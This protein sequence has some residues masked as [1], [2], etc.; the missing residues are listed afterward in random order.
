M[1]QEICEGLVAIH[2]HH[3]PLVHGDLT[4]VNVLFNENYNIKIIDFGITQQEYENGEPVIRTKTCMGNPRF[5]SP[6]TINGLPIST[7]DDI[8]QLGNI[9]YEM[10]TRTLPLSEFDVLASGDLINQRAISYGLRA[11]LPTNCP[12]QWASLI[13]RCWSVDRAQ[14]PSAKEI[15][16]ILSEMDVN[17]RIETLYV[18]TLKDQL[19]KNVKLDHKVMLEAINN[20]SIEKRRN[21]QQQLN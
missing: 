8:F 4:S 12:K 5:L 11:T 3:T 20:L 7:A 9:I 16:E 1:V 18:P 6:D 15:L 17:K 2:H 14:R 21:S 19:P 13:N 10:I